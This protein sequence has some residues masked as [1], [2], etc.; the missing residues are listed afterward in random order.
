MNQV[1]RIYKYR[2]Y[3]GELFFDCENSKCEG[4]LVEFLFWDADEI[5]KKLVKPLNQHRFELCQR[6]GNDLIWSG[7]WG[8]RPVSESII[9]LLNGGHYMSSTVILSAIVENS[10]NNLLWASLVDS[11]ITRENANKF[12]DEKLSRH[13]TIK[14]IHSITNWQ[15]DDISFPV[16]NLVAHGKGF[17]KTEQEYLQSLQEQ[18]ISIREW[19]NKFL[20]LQSPNHFMPTEKERWLLFMD[21]WSQWLVSFIQSKVEEKESVV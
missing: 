15:I 9:A 11:G 7:Y 8:D 6:C 16:R 13:A 10:L 12:S 5:G 19:V 14:R 1:E 20:A 4:Y 2:I 3:E 18:A 21:C 17:G